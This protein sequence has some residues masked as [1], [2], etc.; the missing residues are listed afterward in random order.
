MRERYLLGMTAVPF[1][2]AALMPGGLLGGDEVT[3]FQDPAIVESSGLVA[4]GDGT[5]VTTNDS[6]DSG[7]VFTVDPATGETVRVTRWGSGDPEDVEALAPV[8]DGSVWV[9]DIGDNG[10][11]RSHVS[12]TQV[13][14]AGVDLDTPTYD[15][16]YPGGRPRRGVVAVRPDDRPAVRRQ[17]GRLRRHPVR[18]PA[19]AGR[20]QAEPP[21]GGRADAGD[22]DGRGVLPRRAAPDRPQLHRGGGVLLARARGRR[23]LRAARSSGRARASRSRRTARST[24]RRRACTRRCCGSACPTRYAAP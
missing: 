3:R 2:V 20:R 11:D 16:V 6:G 15:L 13:G 17:Q 24:P 5:L 1:L 7:R 22:G 18:R 9:G 21:R 14:V 10:A 8:G 12:V 23:A 4:L 19:A